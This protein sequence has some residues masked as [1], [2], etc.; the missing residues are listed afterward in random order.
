MAHFT[1]LKSALYQISGEYNM[2]TWWLPT[3]AVA[4]GYPLVLPSTSICWYKVLTGPCE[5]CP[6]YGN[7]SKYAGSSEVCSPALQR[8]YHRRPATRYF[9]RISY[10]TSRTTYH[11][12]P[13]PHGPSSTNCNNR[14]PRRHHRGSGRRS[15][16][17]LGTP[18]MGNGSMFLGRIC[19]TSSSGMQGIHGL[20]GSPSSQKR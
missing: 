2:S 3:T 5:E 16:E 14:C 13:P 6:M 15:G 8:G 18:P 4:G 20:S 19:G 9:A 12:R 17:C 10:K 7:E 11:K 1:R